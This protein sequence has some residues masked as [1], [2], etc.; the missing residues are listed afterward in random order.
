M[1]QQDRHGLIWVSLI[2]EAWM[3]IIAGTMIRTVLMMDLA[4][5]GYT[6][7]ERF[8]LL[9]A[10]KRNISDERLLRQRDSLQSN[11]VNLAHS[12]KTA[13]LLCYLNTHR[14]PYADLMMVKGHQEQVLGYFYLS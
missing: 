13:E 3:E 11:L 4:G 10:A 2:T 7:I 1:F 8:G 9:T 12:V 14:G 5:P 6:M